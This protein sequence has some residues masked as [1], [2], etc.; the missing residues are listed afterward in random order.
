MNHARDLK[1]NTLISCEKLEDPY[2]FLY[3]PICYYGC[4]S[5]LQNIKHNLVYKMPKLCKLDF[6][7]LPDLLRLR[8]RPL[9][10]FWQTLLWFWVTF[11]P[12]SRLAVSHL[13]SP[14]ICG[15]WCLIHWCNSMYILFLVTFVWASYI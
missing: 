7:Y 6:S 1:L 14:L 4:R 3:P 10:H 2:L 8:S 11:V 5:L 13:Y 9:G 15:S 12:F